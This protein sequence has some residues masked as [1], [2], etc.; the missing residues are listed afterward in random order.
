MI[1]YYLNGIECNP[2]NKDSVEYTFDFTDRKVRELELSVDALTFVREDFT[3]VKEWKALY[4]R[5]VG[6]P[7]DI[8]YSNG[9]TIKY[10]LDFQDE[11][12]RETLRSVTVKLKRYKG[13]D[14]FFDD[15]NGLSFGSITWQASDFVNVDYVVIAP[16]QLPYFISLAFGIFNLAQELVNAVKESVDASTELIK[17]V[18][19]VGAPIPGPDWGAI[20][21]VAIRTISRIIWTLLIIIALIKLI[22]EMI[23]IVFPQIRQFKA[24]TVKRLVEKGCAHL[25]Y[26]LSSTL[27]NSLDKLVICPVPLKEK[28]PT[29]W[30][31]I[32]APMSL[33]FTN[34]YPSFRDTTPLFGQLL[35]QIETIFN[36]K[37]KVVNGVVTIENEIFFEQ[38]A[39][40]N[41]L[42]AFN[43]QAGLNS[44]NTWNTEDIFKRLV[45]F[46]QTDT[47]DINTFDDTKGTLAEISSEVVTTP[48][49]NL[50]MIKGVDNINIAF[51]RGTRKGELT[52][53]EKE[54]KQ[55]AKAIDIFTGGN[56]SAQIDARKDVMQI[57]SQYFEK[58]K[59]LWM[60]GTKLH[61]NQNAVLSC[62]N[63]INNYH[64]NR[65][66]Q[67]NQK[68]VVE[69][70][71][72]ALTE[73][74]IFNILLNNFVTLNSGEV[75]E[76]RRLTW[77]ERE[78][79]ANI[80]Y[81]VRKT[82]I[83]EQTTVINAG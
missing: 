74:E 51:A 14:N 33:A 49:V 43:D 24:C 61:S 67:N 15:A 32:F 69:N 40:G 64:S 5:F 53:F 58:S 62:I 21:I 78:H 35:E 7:L 77:S 17:A 6:M 68:D 8:V 4:G 27:L 1:R 46:Y 79:M 22:V 12:Y 56:A 42:K 25:N 55:L 2:A 45:A 39:N 73:S 66:I 48:D 72:V 31:E 16:D 34:G 26:T 29:L 36:A 65:F 13:I 81:T 18:V 3:A 70:M 52:L 80:D 30:K 47:A 38:A 41:I 19:P 57:S 9:T 59:L 20:I 10:I 44:E 75:A 63:I 28:D 71:P 50:N 37:T 54:V 83:N 82:G 11:S 76:I 60:N 23:N